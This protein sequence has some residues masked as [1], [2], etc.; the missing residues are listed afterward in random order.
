MTITKMTLQKS[1]EGKKIHYVRS[2]CIIIATS[3]SG[4][5]TA[6]QNVSASFPQNH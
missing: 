2:L 6:L 1:F 5:K 3:C 4:W